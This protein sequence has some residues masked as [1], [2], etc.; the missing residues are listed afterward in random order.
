MALP[1]PISFF[2]FLKVFDSGFGYK[3]HQFHCPE[4]CSDSVFLEYVSNSESKLWS[5]TVLSSLLETPAQ[6]NTMNLQY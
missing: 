1:N 4:E 5:A 2:F 6:A 3:F